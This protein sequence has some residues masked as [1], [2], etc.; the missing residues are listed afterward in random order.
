MRNPDH[1]PQRFVEMRVGKR[2]QFI[3]VSKDD[4]TLIIGHRVN[5]DGSKFERETKTT[6]EEFVVIGTPK[7]IIREMRMSKH[8][9]MLEPV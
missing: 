8:Y 4:G 5:R 7:C 9:G 1:L 6:V 2:R 3:K